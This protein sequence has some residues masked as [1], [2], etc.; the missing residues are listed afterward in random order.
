MSGHFGAL[1]IKQFIDGGLHHI[2]TS[3]LIC[4]ESQWTGFYMIGTSAMKELKDQIYATVK[5]KIILKI[6]ENPDITLQTMKYLY[7]FKILKE[8]N[9][10]STKITVSRSK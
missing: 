9:V 1:C 3:P 10:T 7:V 2:E 5:K 8:V 4:S 6:L